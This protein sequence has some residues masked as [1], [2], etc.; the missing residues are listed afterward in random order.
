[1]QKSDHSIFNRKR[2]GSLPTSDAEVSLNEISGGLKVDYK[3][4]YIPFEANLYN[5]T[6]YLWTTLLFLEGEITSKTE[7]LTV[8]LPYFA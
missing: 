8:S 6:T 3:S 1:M 2:L 5:V 7:Y 4:S